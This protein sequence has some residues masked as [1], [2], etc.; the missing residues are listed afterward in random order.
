MDN[1]YII[2]ALNNMSIDLSQTGIYQNNG[3][4][5]ARVTEII[6]NMIHSDSL[7]YWA[8]SLGFRGIKYKDELNRAANV[9]TEAHQAIEIFL[10]EKLS[11]E[12]NIPFLGFKLWYDI[13]TKNIGIPIKVIFVEHTITCQ[14][15][16]GT[17]DALLMI[18]DK[19]Y[20]VDFKTSNH[21]T[22]K[23]FIQLSAY[24]YML[25]NI[26]GIDIDGVIVLQ[27]DKTEPGFNE[28]LLNFS[29]KDHLE[30]IDKCENTFLSLV[31]AYYNVKEIER[32]YSNISVY[33]EV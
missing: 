13:V 29:I 4:P 21:V 1:H 27:L 23:Y 32:E 31:Y 6:S 18:G 7:M 20:L 11:A 8:N 17:L 16:G 24:R 10:K 5:V 30:F 2:Q 19:I 25:K 14:W 26:E 28:Y 15:F 3:K 12:N 33:K 9:G 22:Y